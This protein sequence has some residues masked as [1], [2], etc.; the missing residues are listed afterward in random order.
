MSFSRA[1]VREP[2]VD[3]RAVIFDSSVRT[4]LLRLVGQ[5]RPVPFVGE[6]LRPD[7]SLSMEESSVC[8]LASADARAIFSF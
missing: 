2:R 8:R 7:I 6:I 4:R 1:A 5:H 3:E